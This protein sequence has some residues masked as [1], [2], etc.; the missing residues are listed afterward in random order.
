VVG[1]NQNPTLG[2]NEVMSVKATFAL[3]SIVNRY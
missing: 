2:Q 1:L 3:Q